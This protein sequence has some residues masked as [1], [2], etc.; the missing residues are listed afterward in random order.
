[1]GPRNWSARS[2]ARRSSGARRR[3]VS[4][5]EF[6]LVAPALILLYVGT[7]EIGNALTVYRRTAQ[8]AATAADLTAQVRPSRSPTSGY[9]GGLE[10][11]SH[12]LSPT[13]SRSCCRAWSPTTTTRAKSTGAA[14]TAARAPSDPLEGPG[15]TD[16]AR[17][18]ASS[19]RKSTTNIR[20]L[21]LTGFFSPGSF[22]MTSTFYTRPRKSMAVTKTDNGC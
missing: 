1:M 9:P 13:R 11:H 6:A 21:G 20:P 8:V 15:G 10:Q 17:T 18:A 5:I 12:A 2:A 3:G 19:S 14:P 7:V 16:R 22:D 4:A